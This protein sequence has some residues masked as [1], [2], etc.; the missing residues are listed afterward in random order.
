MLTGRQK[1]IYTNNSP[2]TLHALHMNLYVN[3]FRKNSRM[4]RYHEERDKYYGGSLI[5]Y[6]PEAYLGYSKVQNIRDEPGRLLSQR[7]DD[8]LLEITL[9]E[10]IQPGGVC[11]L[12]L[13]FEVKIPAQIRRMGRFNREGVS[14]SIAQ[15]YPKLCVYDHRGWHKN[16]YLAREFFGEFAT[17]DVSITLPAHYIVGASGHLTN[18]ENIHAMMMSEPEST[19]MDRVLS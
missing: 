1:I 10:P 19:S 6:V 16:Y 18:A 14:F 4:H 7:E 15:W 5:S 12:T 3:A 13:D 11:T 2:D 9:A 8:T 17:W